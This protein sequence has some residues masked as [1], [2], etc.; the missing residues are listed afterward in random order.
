[1][2]LSAL[3]PKIHGPSR[4][5]V[6]K[7]I[8]V[9]C[10][11]VVI[12]LVLGGCKAESTLTVDVRDGASG[13]VKLLIELDEEAASAIRRDAYNATSLSNV[14]NTDELKKAGF[15]VN[16]KDNNS[17]D[18][19]K[20]EIKANFQNEKE[21]KSIFAAFAPPEVLDAS[22]KVNSS[23]IEVKQNTKITVDLSTLRK[24]YLE[25]KGV[26]D[27]LAEVGI[28]QSEFETL[29]NSVL[30]STTLIVELNQGGK[31]PNETIKGTDNEKTIVQA[32]TS[33]FR[34]EYFFYMVGAIV[35]GLIGLF[36]LWRFSRMPR[37]LSKKATKEQRESLANMMK[38]ESELD[39]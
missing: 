32:S 12:S 29:I 26:K 33:S 39:E 36:L 21:L 3:T 37:L 16:I 34:S 27:A 25:D 14:F 1:M 18:P 8:M 7:S 28:E 11:I 20:I 6:R 35:S 9:T 31:T 19:S 17:G 30:S 22:L 38:Y 15:K 23:F 10:L 4:F 13:S 24:Y 2:K 5:S